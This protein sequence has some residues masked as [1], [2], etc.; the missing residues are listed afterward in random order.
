[1]TSSLSLYLAHKPKM[2]KPGMQREERER[3]MEGLLVSVQ[4]FGG[5]LDDSEEQEAE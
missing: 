4:C 3:G 5:I 2:V 1:M